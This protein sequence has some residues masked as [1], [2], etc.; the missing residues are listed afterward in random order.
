MRAHILFL[1]LAFAVPVRAIAA[2]IPRMKMSL[3]V[4]SRDLSPSSR[5]VG[6]SQL[7]QR[8]SC[9]RRV[10]ETAGL[11]SRTRD[12]RRNVIRKVATRLRLS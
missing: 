5:P 9:R 2:S 11:L 8:L 12:G 10:F 7:S 6:Q 1:H 4:P 3:I